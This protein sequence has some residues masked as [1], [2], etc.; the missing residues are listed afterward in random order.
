MIVQA[1]REIQA[2]RGY[3][4]EEE[5]T[6][7]ASRAQVPLCRIQEIAS[8]FP[9]YRL[10]KAPDVEIQVCRDMACHLRGAD[11]LLAQASQLVESHGLT[12][13]TT[14]RGVSCL[15]RCDRSPATHISR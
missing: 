3:L 14:V 11:A 2:R 12:A 15:G 8:F 9:H 13:R 10:H 7:L 6:T 4:P 5:L 1:L